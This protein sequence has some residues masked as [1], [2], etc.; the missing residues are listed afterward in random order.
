MD[1][2]VGD[3][4][5]DDVPD[6]VP[7][8]F[9]AESPDTELPGVG[10]SSWDDT[11]DLDGDDEQPDPG[12]LSDGEHPV[13]SETVDFATEDSTAEA[14]APDLPGD[15][16]PDVPAGTGDTDLTDDTDGIPVLG[17]D[18]PVGLGSDPDAPPA[19]SG[20][21]DWLDLPDLANVEVPEPAG[22]PPWVDTGLLGDSDGDLE[23]VP[24]TG[25]SI[26][27]TPG[28]GADDLRASLGEPPLV[29]D[30]TDSAY[31]DL[32]ASDDPAVR[33]LAR[34]WGPPV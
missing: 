20:D 23:D 18:S 14:G 13:G 22:G 15:A 12:W 32:V 34:L 26:P 27:A 11:V 10:D 6:D 28:G 5:P 21:G 29:G 33:N 3:D 19:D 2:H 24:V 8:D 25:D 31:Q 4:F 16:D 30:P 1:G 7:D 17:D 9:S